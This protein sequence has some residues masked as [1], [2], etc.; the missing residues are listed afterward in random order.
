MQHVGILY[1]IV[2]NAQQIIQSPMAFV[3]LSRL[4]LNGNDLCFI[5]LDYKI[6]F[7]HTLV[8]EI[9]QLASMSSKLLRNNILVERAIVDGN[10]VVK[11]ISDDIHIAKPGKQANIGKE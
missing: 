9:K 11:N 3:V 2:H 4:D 8:I 10:A 7:S 5:R 6:N 1:V